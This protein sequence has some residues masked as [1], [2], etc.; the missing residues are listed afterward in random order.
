MISHTGEQR[1]PIHA[2]SIVIAPSMLKCATLTIPTCLAGGSARGV[3]C[4]ALSNSVFSQTTRC[5]SAFFAP[6]A[7]LYSFALRSVLCGT[8]LKL[9]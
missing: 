8:D 5:S 2:T 9:S 7:A 6:A 1:M 4:G 3:W